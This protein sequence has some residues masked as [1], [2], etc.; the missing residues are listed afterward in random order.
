MVVLLSFLV[1]TIAYT[2]CTLHRYCVF[3]DTVNTAARME[4]TS[5]PQKIQISDITQK[6]LRDHFPN[7]F[8]IVYRGETTVKVNKFL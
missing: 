1:Y 3:G 7:D 4:S 2:Y 6:F 8:D 5:E